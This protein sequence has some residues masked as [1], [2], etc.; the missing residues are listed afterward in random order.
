MLSEGDV[1]MKRIV[2]GLL[3][4]MIVI[5]CF[6]SFLGVPQT[7]SKEYPAI[8][9]DSKNE[10][11]Y[12]ET[13]VLIKGT[14]IKKLFRGDEF[15]GRIEIGT[16]EL[17]K[18]EGTEILLFHQYIPNGYMGIINAYQSFPGQIPKI[19]QGVAF[20]QTTKD[21]SQISFHIVD[22]SIKVIAPTTTLEEAK[23]LYQELSKIH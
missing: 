19:L 17:T 22:T 5:I 11:N 16:N 20:F 8:Q 1:K 7:I 21:F 6:L 14:L 10:D 3:G 12:T 13:T 15:K 4:V 9:F 2:I 23:M 18:S